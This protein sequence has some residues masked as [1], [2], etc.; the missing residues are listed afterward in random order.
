MTM[1]VVIHDLVSGECE[2][3]G[4]AN[5]ECVRVSFDEKTPEAII[6]TAEFVKLLRFKKKQEEKKDLPRSPPPAGKPDGK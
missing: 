1:N 2:L 4:K 5:V 6:S 3:S